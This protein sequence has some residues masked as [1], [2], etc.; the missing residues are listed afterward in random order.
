MAKP[1]ASAMFLQIAMLLVFDTLSRLPSEMEPCTFRQQ[2]VK[3]D[4]ETPM[5]GTWIHATERFRCTAPHER[6]QPMSYISSILYFV[7]TTSGAALHSRQSQRPQHY[8]E[9]LILLEDV[10]CLLQ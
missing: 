1:A 4:R 6:L 9:L 3:T 7:D 10:G 8:C 2:T 5:A